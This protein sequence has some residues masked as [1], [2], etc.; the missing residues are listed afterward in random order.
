[1][2]ARRYRSCE[3]VSAADTPNLRCSSATTGRITDRFCLSDR[4][5]PSSTSNSS[6]PIHIPAAQ[7]G[8]VEDGGGVEAGAGVEGGAGAGA[9]VGPG[10]GALGTG[11]L[12]RANNI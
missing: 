6:Q 1:M 11:E 4:T 12:L 10:G 9:E 8:G 7:P 3:P 2:P 5:S